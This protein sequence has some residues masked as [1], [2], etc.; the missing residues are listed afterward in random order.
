MFNTQK[1]IPLCV[2]DLG[3]AITYFS[4]YLSSTCRDSSS[5]PSLCHV[6]QVGESHRE[7]ENRFSNFFC[8]LHTLKLS[9]S[10]NS[11]A[12]RTQTQ[13]PHQKRKEDRYL[14]YFIYSLRRRLRSDSMVRVRNSGKEET[15]RSSI[16]NFCLKLTKEATKK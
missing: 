14:F 4:F 15:Q 6:M 8:F 2:S 12:C 9:K 16:E 3:W 13:N 11:K 1:I 7:K 5:L 10:Y